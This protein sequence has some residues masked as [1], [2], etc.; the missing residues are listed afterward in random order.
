MMKKH[1]ILLAASGLLVLAA[2]SE[3]E[4]PGTQSES[5]QTASDDTSADRVP[6]SS[7]SAVDQDNEDR[8][9]IDE[10]GVSA[11]IRDD[12]NKVSLD[13]DGDVSASVKTD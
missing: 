13:H 6:M 12:G 7:D 9:T 3:A 8:I 2:C 5:E 1:S 11:T 4:A 10:N